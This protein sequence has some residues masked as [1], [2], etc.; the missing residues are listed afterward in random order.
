MVWSPRIRVIERPIS[1]RPLGAPSQAP[2]THNALRRL[3]RRIAA[4]G[5]LSLFASLSPLL[6]LPFV[7]RS[8]PAQTWAT[9]LTCQTVGQ[10][11][12]LVLLAGWGVDG[13]ARVAASRS[14]DVRRSLY[15]AAFRQRLRLSLALVPLAVCL[16]VLLARGYSP[17]THALM[18]VAGTWSGFSVGW[19]A[20]GSGQPA[21]IAKYE[22]APRLA[23][24]ASA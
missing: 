15:V 13:Q 2:R 5:G 18:C 23:A 22:A 9:L 14:A 11:L 8:V 20:I 19:Y 24:S 7:A 3:L 4:F 12:G 6:V 1:Q 21:W 16:G 17:G 10:L